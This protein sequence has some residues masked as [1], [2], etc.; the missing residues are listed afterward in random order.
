MLSTR[1]LS[2]V[3]ACALLVSVRCEPVYDIIF[4]DRPLRTSD[5]QSTSS[6]DLVPVRLHNGSL[7]VCKTTE[8][9]TVDSEEESLTPRQKLSREQAVSLEKSL[10]R[11]KC[12]SAIYD[13]VRVVLCWA[14]YIGHLSSQPG[15]THVHVIAVSNSY[16][17]SYTPKPSLSLNYTVDASVVTPIQE[18]TYEEDF[19]GPHIRTDFVVPFKGT[20][21]YFQYTSVVVKLYC[22]SEGMQKK[23]FFV[24]ELQPLVL[25]V[26]GFVEEVC[27]YTTAPIDSSE[28]PIVCFPV[29]A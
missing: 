27:G 16:N 9:E 8:E 12:D 24:R 22:A 1:I 11:R 21:P 20:M 18:Y 28:S 25:E 19:M 23:N 10:Q 29:F 26:Q 5:L 15:G 6:E 4:S 7:Y 14:Y 13:H 2:L 3:L 17:R